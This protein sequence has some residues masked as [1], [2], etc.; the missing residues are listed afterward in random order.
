M[1]VL[2]LFLYPMIG[3]NQLV[4]TDLTQA[5]PLTLAAA[6]G[7]LIFGHVDFG[8]T[9]SLV[10]GS[11][12]AV[13]IG[14]TLSSRVSDRYI[15][16]VIAFVIFAS[17]LKYIGVGNR[18]A[19]LDPRRR[20]P[21]RSRRLADRRTLPPA[22]GRNDRAGPERP[23]ANRRGV[24]RDRDVRE[25]ELLAAAHADRIVELDDVAAARAL[26]AQLP[27]LRPEQNGRG[28]ADERHAR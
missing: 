19:R 6:I 27:V 4:G 26:T 15:R 16:P 2:L 7:A 9:A 22:R 25:L 5:V 12:P 3:A 20:V 8:V 11:V 13:L 10:V 24:G 14:A 17:G 1:I 23:S 18:D 28:E 21:R